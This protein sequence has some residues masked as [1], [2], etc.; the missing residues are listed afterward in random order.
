M[1]W[2][3]AGGVLH[4]TV[5]EGVD[6]VVHLAGE[7]I[8]QRW[9]P[10]AKRRIRDSRVIGTRLIAET[11][12]RLDKGP[13]VLIVSSATGYYGSRGDEWLDEG[14]APGTDFLAEATGAW[15]RAADAA[16]AAGVRVVHVRTGL[17]MSPR[18]GALA[19]LLTPFR[20]GVGGRLGDGR[21]WMSWIALDDL[22]AV[23][24]FALDTDVLTG[25]VNAVSPSPVTNAEFTSTLAR[26][27]SRPA[28][29]TLPAI[30]LRALFGEM[31]VGT[32]LASQRARPLV[33]E[34]AGF[35]F[36]YPVLE[37]ALRHVL[38]R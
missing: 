36:A 35:R 24:R 8:A 3:P 11:M 28:V 20:F 38:G 17:A 29:M 30:A 7:T 13:R 16:R 2:D 15:E 32:L 25:A 34:R 18:G 23:F 22:V 14:S 5:L 33:L 12:A 31:A 10:A 9:T 1:V 21:Q 37:D 26:A 19:K 6:A 27:L 4:A